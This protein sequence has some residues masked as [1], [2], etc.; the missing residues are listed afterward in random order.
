MA[1]YYDNDV[2]Q[3][4]IVEYLGYEPEERKTDQHALKLRKEVLTEVGKIING[5]IFTHKFT[6]WENYDDLYQEATEACIKALEKFN[7]EYVTTKGVKATSFNYFSLTAKRCLKFYTIR[8]KK[9]RDNQHI[10]NF[11]YKLYINEDHSSTINIV[12]QNFI[13]QIK[14]SIE[15]TKHKKFLELV[16]ILE[17]Y[18]YKMGD[19]NKRDFFRFAKSYGWSPSLIRKFLKIIKDNKEQIYDDIMEDMESGHVIDV[20][21]V[22]NHDYMKIME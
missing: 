19:Y 3:C 10:D 4:K 8:N 5:I 9:N 16:K 12:V 15:G 6:V 21:G 13:D 2:V 1:N 11:A 20:E 22:H 17:E 18:L 14:R 7:P